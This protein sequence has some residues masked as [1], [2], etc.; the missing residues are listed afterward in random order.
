MRGKMW[1]LTGAA[2]GFVL[3]ARAG[4]ETYDQLVQT[5]RRVWEH[6]TTQETAGVVQEQTNRLYHRGKET[7]SGKIGQTRAAGRFGK[8]EQHAEELGKAG[9]ETL[10]EEPRPQPGSTF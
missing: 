6:P 5:A 1:F 9:V 10:T 4:R 8:R 3:G 2:V 7:M